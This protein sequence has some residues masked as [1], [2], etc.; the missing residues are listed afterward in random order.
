MS[1]KRI[2]VVGVGTAG[3]KVVDCVAMSGVEVPEMVAIST[4]SAILATSRA[5]LR[6]EIGTERTRG[7][8]TGNDPAIGRQAA[9]DDEA[10]IRAQFDGISLAFVVAGL[11]GGTGS[12]ATP[13][14]VR[15]AR[16]AGALTLCFATT[17]CRR[18]ATPIKENGFDIVFFADG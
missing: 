6:L 18:S 1:D 16:E 3:C 12:G 14:V 17:P 9:E 15:C 5:A 8:G 11:G 7:L 4:D 13:V 10:A 2:K